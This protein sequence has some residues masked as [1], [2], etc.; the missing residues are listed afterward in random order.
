MMAFDDEGGTG[1]AGTL[2]T[3]PVPGRQASASG[4][5]PFYVGEFCTTEESIAQ[6]GPETVQLLTPP[7]AL[8]GSAETF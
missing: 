4:H 7:P 2:N 8:R 5:A 3:V 6:Y 1:L